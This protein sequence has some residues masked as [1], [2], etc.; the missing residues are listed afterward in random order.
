MKR[1]ILIIYALLFCA[2]IN[3]YSQSAHYLRC[4]SINVLNDVTL[5]WEIPTTA[6]E[7]S[8]YKIYQAEVSNPTAFVEIFSSS[9]ITT[10]SYVHSGGSAGQTINLYYIETALNNGS[11]IYSD[12][13]RTLL[14]QAVDDGE[15]EVILSWNNMHNPP[16]PSVSNTFNIFLEYPQNSWNHIGSTS[17]NDYA[18]EINICEDSLS[19]QV[20][21]QDDWG[22]TSSS[23]VAGGVY[24]DIIKPPMP[25]IDSVSIDP[26]DQE[27]VIGWETSLAPDANAYLIYRYINSNWIPIDTIWGRQ[28]T[29]YKDIGVH[30]CTQ[31]QAY[32]LATLDSCGNKSLG[33][34]LL[35]QQSILLQDILFDPCLPATILTWSPY[36]N[37]EP[38]LSGY[39]V[40][41]S[42]ESGPFQLVGTTSAGQTSY[43]H[44]NV[45]TDKHYTYYIRAFNTKNHGSSSCKKTVFTPQYAKPTF[46]YLANVSVD[47]NT[48]IN[49]TIY[50]DTTA[51]VQQ[52]KIFRMDESSGIY[53]EITMISPGDDDVLTYEDQEVNIHQQSYEYK[54]S[55]IDSCGQETLTSN[56]IP[57]ILLQGSII[58]ENEVYLEWNVLS[59]WDGNV[60]AYDVFR[61]F[62]DIPEST[63]IASL[64]A[65]TQEYTDNISEAGN[66]VSSFDY[67]VVAREASG[68]T[69]GFQESS[70]SNIIQLQAAPRIYMPN[71]FRPDGIN[72]VFK[73][74]GN[75]VDQSNYTFQIYDRWG[76][77]VFETN[78]FS[79]GWNGSYRGKASPVGVYIYILKYRLPDGGTTSLKGSFVL[80]R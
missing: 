47:N 55:I 25:I 60:Q 65:T 73:P 36:I 13:L 70:Y 8:A 11:S 28:N 2:G 5:T 51:V 42:M 59:G 79:E 78:S 14:L 12:T 23:N 74:V 24:Q 67:V 58:S 18:H 40:Y 43:V 72:S 9:I 77:L 22:C 29:V 49:I 54:T 71:A 38:S 75:Y 27:I 6:P 17:T 31:S 10:T 63:P 53:E 1:L 52:V 16:L 69:Y 62:D 37:M 80:L 64:P 33:T 32:A 19:F 41:A 44:E 35:P 26:V 7:F 48:H 76:S 45:E 3:V 61:I 15:G 50:I 56:V 57:S 68:N 20:V 39:Q 30:P 4:L 46:N 21:L 34:F 66:T